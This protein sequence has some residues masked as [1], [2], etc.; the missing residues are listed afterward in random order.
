MCRA[1]L[2]GEELDGGGL[3]VAAPLEALLEALPS[4]GLPGVLT[5]FSPRLASSLFRLDRLSRF[6]LPV[7][8][9]QEGPCYSLLDLV[10]PGVLAGA[11]LL[12][13]LALAELECAWPRV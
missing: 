1:L 2:L 10:P 13:G 4:L 11:S 7:A 5:T 3:C 9:L 8:A 12:L 6:W